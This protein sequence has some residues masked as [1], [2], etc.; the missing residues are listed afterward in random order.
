[1]NRLFEKIILNKYD[2]IFFDIFDTLIERD[3]LEPTD[4]F[5]IVGKKMNHNN[6]KEER[7]EA[8][9]RARIGSCSGEV[10]LRDIYQYIKCNDDTDKMM[11]CEILTEIEY[12]HVKKAILDFYKKCIRNKTVVLVSDMYLPKTVIESMLEKCGIND[13]SQIYISCEHGISKRNGGLFKKVIDD[14]SYNKLA[15][16]H[17]GDSFKTDFLGSMRAGINCVM[18][19]KSN[20]I[21]RC[22][23][24][25]KNILKIKY[26][27]IM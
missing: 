12:I 22:W 2:I 23:N 3:V 25:G 20:F 13:Y 18:I 26:F 1:M 21:K 27:E 10:S 24:K 19:R 15:I 11:C 16:I 8:E 7:I 5:E 14:N 4:I 6:F 17:I 9:K